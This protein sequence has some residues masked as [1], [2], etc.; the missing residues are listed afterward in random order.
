M[1]TGHHAY[2]E[3]DGK[4]EKAPLIKWGHYRRRGWVFSTIEAYN[5]QEH[6]TAPAPVVEEEDGDELPTMENTKAEILA[7]A[8]ANDVGVNPEDTKAELLEVIEDALG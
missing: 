1:T 3:K 5:A 6:G 4:V 8:K 2:F 7:Y